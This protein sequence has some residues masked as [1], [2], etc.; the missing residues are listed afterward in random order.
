VNLV[1]WNGNTRREESELEPSWPDGNQR[2]AY[3]E[4][5]EPQQYRHVDEDSEVVEFSML[6]SLYFLATRVLLQIISRLGDNNNK[7]AD[8]KFWRQLSGVTFLLYN[9][10]CCRVVASSDLFCQ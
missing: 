5:V 9:I 8:I 4:G 7:T 3:E 2:N 6:A 10:F 1:S